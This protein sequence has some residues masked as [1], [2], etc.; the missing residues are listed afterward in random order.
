MAQELD[1]A[2][3]LNRIVDQQMFQNTQLLQVLEEQDRKIQQQA[4]SLGELRRAFDEQKL[5][6]KQILQDQ[7]TLQR[8]IL[9]KV[10]NQPVPVT[11]NTSSPPGAAG[12]PPFMTDLRARI[13]N[14]ERLLMISFS[15]GGLNSIFL[16]ATIYL[17]RRPAALVERVFQK[18]DNGQTVTGSHTTI[19][20]KQELKAVN[21]GRPL[22]EVQTRQGRLAL[23]NTGKTTAD[24]IKLFLGLTASN[25]E[26]R[27]KIVTTI[28]SGGRVE[29][30]VSSYPIHDFL[31]GNLEYKNPTNGRLYKDQFILKYHEQTGDLVL[32]NPLPRVE[33]L[34][35]I[36]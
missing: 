29:V 6:Q 36:A 33:E 14:L 31:Y 13:R 1:V 5:S 3:R 28:Q 20:R 23:V 22:V 26:R 34:E 2:G 12:T 15:V 19:K 30:D 10:S 21:M 4:Q 7:E 11:I 35:E 16:L 9:E 25:L 27:Q 32:A 8:Q 18:R 17:I 24:H